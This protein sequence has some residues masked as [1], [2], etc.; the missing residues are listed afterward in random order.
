MDYLS[1]RKQ[2][3]KINSTL[4]KWTDIILGVPQGSIVGPLLFN[5]FINDIFLFVKKIKITNYA[6]DNTP[7]RC[8]R[9]INSTINYLENETNILMEWFTDNYMKANT[10]KCHLIV[11]NTDIV[12]SR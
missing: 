6:D 5:I 10:D 11:T 7:Y 9:D 12:Q 8:D 1:R 3:V 2:R 4:S